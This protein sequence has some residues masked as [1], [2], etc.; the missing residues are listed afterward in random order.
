MRLLEERVEISAPA[1]QVWGLLADFG[2]VAAWAPYMRRSQLLDGPSAGIG[3]RRGMRHAWGF[4]FEEEVTQWHDGK[5]FA[6]DVLKAPFPMKDVKEVWVI[7][8]EDGH[9][10][11]ET[12]VRYGAHLGFIGRFVDWL[13]V[14]FVVRREMRAGLRGL[15][16]HAELLS[17]QEAAPAKPD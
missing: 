10:A 2:N 14:R 5:G 17:G 12:Q 4:R 15:K 8:P 11:V 9:T 16:N 13:L 1:D 3:M 6:F 7:A